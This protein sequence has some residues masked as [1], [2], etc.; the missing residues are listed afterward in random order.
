MKNSMKNTV[1]EKFIK[2]S[3]KLP[4]KIKMPFGK[5]KLITKEWNNNDVELNLLI[6]DCVNLKI[7]LKIY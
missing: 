5:G 1:I 6:Y 3:E 7:I 2:E 4:S